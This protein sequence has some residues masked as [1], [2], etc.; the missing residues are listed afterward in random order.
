MDIRII[1]YFLKVAEEENITKAAQKLNISQPPLSKMIKQLEEELGQPLFVRKTNRLQLTEAGYLLKKNGQAIVEYLEKTQNQLDALKKGISG[2]ISIAAIESA[3]TSFLPDWI[4]SFIRKY[5]NVN[6]DLWSGTTD[7]IVERLNHGVSDIG[8]IRSP[9]ENEE[10]EKITLASEPW[11]VILR[12]DSP[13]NSDDTEYIDL[14]DISNE[15]LIIPAQAGRFVEIQNWFLQFG[16]S[17]KIVLRFTDMI[18][19]VVQVEK[20]PVIG[21]C[22]VSVNSLLKGR[23]IIYKKIKEPVVESKTLIIW[24]KDRYYSQATKEFMKYISEHAHLVKF[25]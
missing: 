5:V 16:V 18:N 17:P 2:T 11:V 22:P 15:P 4:S 6:F 12:K 24:K 13:Y 23:D 19:C 7:D 20:G 21:I 25:E 1:K 14:L 10:F 3:T 8:M 9:F